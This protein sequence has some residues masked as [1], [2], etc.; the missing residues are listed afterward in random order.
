MFPLLAIG[1]VI[2]AVSSV[3]KGAS[4]LAGKLNPTGAASAGG[5]AGGTAHDRGAGVAV[6]RRT[7]GTSCRAERAG[8]PLGTGQR[9]A[10]SE[11]PGLRLAGA[12]P[13]RHGRL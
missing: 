6:R 7:F 3:A 11:R 9:A 8:E 4:W 12:H 2:S 5:K 10:A 13:G 1:G